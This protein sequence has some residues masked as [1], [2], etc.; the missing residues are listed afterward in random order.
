MFTSQSQRFRLIHTE[1][2]AGFALPICPF[3]EYILAEFEL[4]GP[5]CGDGD[6]HLKNGS[7]ATQ[8]S[9]AAAEHF[10]QTMV[11]ESDLQQTHENQLAG[12]GF[13]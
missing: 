10:T 3:D 12:K 11:E 13:S 6:A 9:I 7:F 8:Q 4:F 2:L 5:T 1:A